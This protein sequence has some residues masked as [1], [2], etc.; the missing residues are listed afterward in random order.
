MEYDIH[1]SDATIQKLKADTGDSGGGESGGGD[2]DFSTAEVTLI[3]IPHGEGIVTAPHLRAANVD[4]NDLLLECQ[5]GFEN[6]PFTHNLVL[7]KGVQNQVGIV[8]EGYYKL[9]TVTGGVELDMDTL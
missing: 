1:L 9:P 8:E 6:N 5:F 4:E 3:Y 7:Y 2:S